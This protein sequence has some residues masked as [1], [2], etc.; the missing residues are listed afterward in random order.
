MK[1]LIIILLAVISLSSCYSSQ[2]NTSIEEKNTSLVQIE[3]YE[4]DDEHGLVYGITEEHNQAETKYFKVM[5]PYEAITYDSTNH[6]HYLNMDMFDSN[7]TN[8]SIEVYT[9]RLAGIS[10][11]VG[12]Y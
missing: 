8:Y 6:I 1:N 3:I 4:A 9:Y 2:A 10:D 11:T 5:A 12:V 7:N